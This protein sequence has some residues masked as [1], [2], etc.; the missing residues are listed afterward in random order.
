[1]MFRDWPKGILNRMESPGPQA[2]ESQRRPRPRPVYGWC[3]VAASM[4]ALLALVVGPWLVDWLTPPPP[5]PSQVTRHLSLK[6]LASSLI[7]KVRNQGEAAEDPES[8]L[9]AEEP[10]P[11]SID[12][13]VNDQSSGQWVRFSFSTGPT[14][15]M[16]VITPPKPA[17]LVAL[18]KALVGMILGGGTLAWAL[19]VVSQFRGEFWVYGA[20]AQ[21]TGTL[22]VT[23]FL[24]AMF[25]AA[26]MMLVVLIVVAAVIALLLGVDLPSI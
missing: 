8:P 22:T 1:M 15:S 23:L 21:F 16:T 13:D 17:W 11:V 14:P 6:D 2:N 9:D 26:L 19:G 4:I 18:E 10:D 12:L 24:L 7:D 3:A 25:I 20:A 5:P